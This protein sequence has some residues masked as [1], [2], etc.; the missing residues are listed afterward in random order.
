MRIA[1]KRSFKFKFA[2]VIDF[3]TFI[4]FYFRKKWSKLTRFIANVTAS[5]TQF[6]FKI[7]GF[8][9]VKL[10]WGRGRLARPFI[11]FGTVVLITVVFL[12][13]GVFQKDL[14]VLSSDE[15]DVFVASQSDIVPQPVLVSTAA[16]NTKLRDTT[17]THTVKPGDTL[18][19]IGQKYGVTIDTIRY[20]NNISDTGYLKVGQDLEI[21]PVNGIV[22]TVKAGE[23]IESIAKDFNIAPQAI[24]DFNYLVAPYKL[25]KGM[26]LVLP[27]T[28][29]PKPTPVVVATSGNTN[30][31]T[32]QYGA[33]AYTFIPNAES[34]PAGSGQFVWPTTSHYISQYFSSYHRAIDIA[35][36]GPIFAADDGVVIRSGWWTN[37]YGFAIQIDH[38][39]GYVTTYAHMS[40]LDVNVGQSVSKGQTIGFMGSTGRSTG[41][42]VHF[43][44]QYNGKHLNPLQ[45]Y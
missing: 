43:T 28:R 44:I 38:R 40:R 13:G 2:G 1:E 16:P 12:T 4:P 33:D 17:V 41:P 24:A 35:I 5:F 3:V 8:V 42:H 39:N 37:G 25:T 45:F 34:G 7:K 29:I 20:A 10:I 18:S 22:H 31:T 21:P 11:Y 32:N 30:N 26:E 27:N 23:S 36:P 15:R 14:I 9:T 19:S 6:V